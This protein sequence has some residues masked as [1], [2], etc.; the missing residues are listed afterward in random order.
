MTGEKVGPICSWAGVDDLSNY[1]D[2]LKAAAAAKEATAAAA[3]AS[4]SADVAASMPLA[5][6]AGDDDEEEEEEE[7]AAPSLTNGEWIDYYL[8]KNLN[9]PPKEDYAEFNEAFINTVQMAERVATEREELKK[10][11][12]DDKKQSKIAK[13]EK[14]LDDLTA[15]TDEPFRE[16]AFLT[17]GKESYLKSVA[18]R[19]CVCL[20]TPFINT[21]L[22]PYI[23]AP[24]KMNKKVMKEMAEKINSELHRVEKLLEM[25]FLSDDDEFEAAAK[26][27]FREC[28]PDLESLFI[29]ESSYRGLVN[30]LSV[31]VLALMQAGRFL[32]A[33]CYLKNRDLSPMLLATEP[34][35]SLARS[36][37]YLDE[38]SLNKIAKKAWDQSC[39]SD[40]PAWYTIKDGKDDKWVAETFA[41]GHTFFG[42][43]LAKIQKFGH[44][45][46]EGKVED[47]DK[48][49]AFQNEIPKVYTWGFAS[50]FMK[51]EDFGKILERI[52]RMSNL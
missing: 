45:L 25:D 13:V 2:G 11:K 20:Q 21:W 28:F 24:S 35:A 3:A 16:C 19:P 15:L 6:T 1:Y 50:D 32:G 29:S 40:Y 31:E 47:E 26:I 8:T 9:A 5:N 10:S 14:M 27:F 37:T 39:P 41:A 34:S 7:E 42:E 52:T 44:W 30:K 48:R 17:S 33:L 23:N 46:S 38:S 51:E 36:A 12:R 18:T 49:A 43:A 4:T 22:E